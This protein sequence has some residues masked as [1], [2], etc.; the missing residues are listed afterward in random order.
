VH[1]LKHWRAFVFS[2]CGLKI[3]PP[4]SRMVVD[5]STVTTYQIEN[6]KDY[7]SMNIQWRNLPNGRMAPKTI[8]IPVLILIALM[9]S[10]PVTEASW[11]IDTKKFYHSGHGEITCQECHEDITES[12]SFIQIPIM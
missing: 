7:L 10:V 5:F 1:R 3:K 8:S 2:A 9:F 6:N 11:W 4:V 12:K